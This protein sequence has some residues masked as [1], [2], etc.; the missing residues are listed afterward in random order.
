MIRTFLKDPDPNLDPNSNP[1]SNT[2]QNVFA[3]A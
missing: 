3:D 2:K 1:Y